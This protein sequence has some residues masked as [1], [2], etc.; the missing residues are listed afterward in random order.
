MPGFPPRHYLM[1]LTQGLRQVSWIVL[2]PLALISALITHNLTLLF[3]THVM[4]AVLWTGS[5][6]FLGIL[7]GPILSTLPPSARKPLLTRLFPKVFWILPI[8]AATTGTAGWF[9][10]HW[11][12]DWTSRMLTAPL[13][14]AI[15]ITSLLTFQ[16]FGLLLPTNY[17]IY[18]MLQSADAPTPAQQQALQQHMRVYKIGVQ[19]QAI[20]QFAI[21][22]VM[23]TIATH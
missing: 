2:F 23:A 13:D 22:F 8:S 12:G 20:A 11:L 7:L 9:L 15:L 10:A 1:T 17:R 16:G 5:D 14:I 4:A 3:Y 6:I 18:R 19:I 21:V